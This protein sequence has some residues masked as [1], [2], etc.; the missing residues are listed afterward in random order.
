[1]VGIENE[2]ISSLMTAIESLLPDVADPALRPMLTLSSTRISPTGLGGFVGTNEVPRGQIVGRRLEATALLTVRA[3]SDSD[4]N[5]AVSALSRALVG[6]DRGALRERGIL[7]IGLSEVRAHAASG[8][9]GIAQRDLT[10]QVV[11]EFLKKPIE[12][13]GT[14]LQVPI[15]IDLSRTG[16]TPRGLFQAPFAEGSLDWFEAVDDPAATRNRPSRWRYDAAQVRIEQ[17]SGLWGGS[18]GANAN[19][20]GTYLVLRTR[21]GLPTVNDF[22]LRTTLRSDNDDG[23]GLVFRWQDGDNFYFFLMNR[24]RRYRML[25]KKVGGLFEPLAT[26][27]MDTTQGFQTRE[28][29]RIRLTAQDS[30]FQVYLNEALVLQ[31]RDASLSAPGRVGFMCH[32]NAA[33]F[34]YTL[35]LRQL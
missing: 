13:A 19:K 22:I 3:P 24:Q 31:G 32:G 10:V 8:P 14:I 1:V 16:T 34:F 6:A 4:L 26:P 18:T 12:A 28:T 29:Y 33:A 15:N 17:R 11:Y 9:D 23:I 20:P 35:D 21:P 2:A 27:A 30:E 25:A 5:S 7:R